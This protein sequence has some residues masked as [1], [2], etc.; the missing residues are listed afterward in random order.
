MRKS[1]ELKGEFD[2]RL[3]AF[4]SDSVKNA[5]LIEEELKSSDKSKGLFLK[6]CREMI[7]K[8]YST[9]KQSEDYSDVIGSL[10][11]AIRSLTTVENDSLHFRS[12]L[13]I[14][15]GV[16]DIPPDDSKQQLKAIP[17][18]VALV[19]VNYSGSVNSIVAGNSIEV[20]NLDRALEKIIRVYNH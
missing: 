7:S 13:L 8:G 18:D 5:A 1:G 20:D 16:Q 19:L 4:R 9:K 10:N 11:A 3:A 2:K 12:I 17:N 15:D 14:S 6:D